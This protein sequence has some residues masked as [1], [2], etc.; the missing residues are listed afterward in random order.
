MRKLPQVRSFLGA[1]NVYRCFVEGFAKI[2]HPLTDMTQKDANPDYDNPTAAQIQACEDFKSR[3]IT[4]PIVELPRYGR[5]YM[6]DTD[7]S[8]YQLGCTL[9]QEHE[10]TDD[11]RRFGY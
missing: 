6:I 4:P 11:W 3:M 2:G 5:P 10:G 9:L 7:A 1:C 8:A